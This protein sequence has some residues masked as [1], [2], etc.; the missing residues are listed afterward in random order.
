MPTRKCN[1]G[2]YAQS[3]VLSLFAIISILIAALGVFAL[4]SFKIQRQEKEIGIRK[5]NG[6]RNSEILLIA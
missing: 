3:R 5:V 2:E 4:A 6:A 1:A